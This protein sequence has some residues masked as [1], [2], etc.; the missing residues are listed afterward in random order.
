MTRGEVLYQVQAHG[1]KEL[2][3]EYLKL[4]KDHV[5]KLL[6]LPGF[7]AAAWFVEEALPTDDQF[8][9]I[10]QYEVETREH[11]ETYFRTLGVVLRS[12][13]QER[14]KGQVAILRKILIKKEAQFSA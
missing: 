9:F 10:V 1:P 14:F 13:A 11:L 6:Q 5:S 7:L 4:I 2:E 12:E 3:A 8:R